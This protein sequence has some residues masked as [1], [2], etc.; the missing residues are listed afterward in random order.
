MEPRKT[1]EIKRVPLPY[2]AEVEKD[3]RIATAFYFNHLLTCMFYFDNS[4]LL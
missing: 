4:F 3:E 2:S 1:V